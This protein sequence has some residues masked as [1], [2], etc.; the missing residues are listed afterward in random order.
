[1]VEH[2]KDFM[3]NIEGLLK[4]KEVSQEAEEVR[5]IPFFHEFIEK[6][7]AM[8]EEAES[9]FPKKNQMWRN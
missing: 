1:M 5:P 7:M 8:C 9:E 2:N 3:E 6:E 4:R